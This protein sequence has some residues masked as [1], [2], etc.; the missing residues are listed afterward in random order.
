MPQSKS[1]QNARIG[2]PWTLID[3]EHVRKQIGGSVRGYQRILSA[4]AS[5]VPVA[6]QSD[7]QPN[8]IYN[9]AS[10]QPD[11]ACVRGLV[12]AAGL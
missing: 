7:G 5:A 11:E 1:A 9:G 10:P 12:S 2:A 4:L 3:V 8:R 6:A